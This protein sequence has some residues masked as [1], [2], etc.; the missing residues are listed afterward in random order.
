MYSEALTPREIPVA[1][2]YLEK[3]TRFAWWPVRVYDSSSRY[4]DGGYWVWLRPVVETE[5][6][7]YDWIAYT[8]DQPGER[9]V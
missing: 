6:M 7:F 2:T 4:L 5:H 8:A 3:R 9:N 1:E